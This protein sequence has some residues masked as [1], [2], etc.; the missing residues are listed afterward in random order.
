M[1]DFNI[2]Q[3]T[4][5]LKLQR[6]YVKNN[7]KIQLCAYK[8]RTSGKHVQIRGT[9]L[10]ACPKKAMEWRQLPNSFRTRLTIANEKGN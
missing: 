4:K 5:M 2:Y 3:K 1:G 10:K 8:S 7:I 9:R 6:N